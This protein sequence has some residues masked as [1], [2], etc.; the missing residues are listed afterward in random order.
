M[1]GRHERVWVRLKIRCNQHWMAALG[2]VCLSPACL[3]LSIAAE[4]HLLL[5]MRQ[6]GRCCSI[7]VMD[8]QLPSTNKTDVSPPSMEALTNT[9]AVSNPGPA[10]FA[11]SPGWHL[12][13]THKSQG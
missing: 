6:D 13:A 9:V 10:S 5:S 2:L 11:R 12:R 7:F 3:R 4:R 8:C 1:D